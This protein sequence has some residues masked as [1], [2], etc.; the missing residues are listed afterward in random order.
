[1]SLNTRDVLNVSANH[2]EDLT[3]HVFD[4]LTVS[5]PI[6]PSVALDLSKVLSKLSPLVANLIEF[7]LVEY[8]NDQTEFREYGSWIRQDPGFP[9]AIFSGSI[10]PTP[11]FEIKA[12]FPL[13]TEITARF[14]DS[15]EHFANDNTQVCMLAWLPEKIVYG[16]PRILDV[17]VVSG[18]SVAK[19][20]DDHYHNPPDYLVLEPGDTKARTKN[21][22]Q[23][24]TNGYKFQGTP[25]EF[26][27]AKGIVASWGLTGSVYKTTEEYQLLLRQL[28]NRYTYRL[29]TNYAKIDRIQH[30]EVEQFKIKVMSSVIEGLTVLEWTSLLFGKSAKA[31]DMARRALRERLGVTEVEVETLLE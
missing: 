11:G 21:L 23:T 26:V 31:Q 25:E 18:A 6:S 2:L 14:K 16:K 9:D 12:W 7:N 27:E 13:A 4:L 20:R 19:A 29:D 8:L 17:C 3:G 15:Q 28:M 1:M 22:Q 30:S 24:N 10:E 5:K